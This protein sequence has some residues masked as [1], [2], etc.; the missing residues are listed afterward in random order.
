MFGYNKI[1][2]IIVILLFFLMIYITKDYRE[3][4]GTRGAPTFPQSVGQY[5]KLKNYSDDDG[6]SYTNR[7]GKI[8]SK[9]IGAT[10]TDDRLTIKLPLINDNSNIENNK[11][12]EV[13]TNATSGEWEAP[14]ISAGRWDKFKTEIESI[15]SGVGNIV[16]LTNIPKEQIGEIIP[17]NKNADQVQQEIPKS[18][19]IVSNTLA[20]VIGENILTSDAT[21]RRTDIYQVKCWVEWD[22][23]IGEWTSSTFS[24]QTYITFY[25]YY[26]Q[27]MGGQIYDSASNEKLQF[28]YILSRWNSNS[29]VVDNLSAANQEYT[30]EVQTLLTDLTSV[31]EEAKEQANRLGVEEVVDVAENIPEPDPPNI[32]VKIN[33]KNAQ[34]KL[35]NYTN[36]SSLSPIVD[37]NVTIDST[38]YIKD[39][40]EKIH[41]KLLLQN[42]T[43][44]VDVQVLSLI[45][46]TT[47]D[48]LDDDTLL[49]QNTIVAE[50]TNEVYLAIDPNYSLSSLP[51]PNGCNKGELNYIDEQC[52]DHIYTFSSGDENY[53]YKYCRPKCVQDECSTTGCATAEECK[54]CNL[55][56]VKEIAGSQGSF[57]SR[58]SWVKNTTEGT[59][60][61]GKLMY[62]FVNNVWSTICNKIDPPE[63]DPCKCCDP[64]SN[65]NLECGE[66]LVNSPAIGASKL[67]DNIQDDV[68]N[69]NQISLENE[70]VNAF[71]NVQTTE[72]MNMNKVVPYEAIWD[73]DVLNHR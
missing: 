47:A 53:K 56:K 11:T 31:V 38:K 3:G 65:K 32:S 16:K 50:N 39:L 41:D 57:Y 4:I 8:V 5:I 52:Y 19:N 62:N 58:D 36:E 26:H 64:I 45:S 70:P 44:P 18:V 71:A 46:D 21:N 9:N 68:S 33:T 30:D 55:Y 48:T 28:D 7:I 29:R 35:S 25:V 23:N 67:F 22:D 63:E 73:V 20:E 12:I 49:S 37:F 69:R 15:D 66:H 72:D 42:V 61:A 59:A 6:I 40:K 27:I 43:L 1:V 2:I 54:G 13:S 51:C 10:S 17:T 24:S 34:N 14:S 60:M